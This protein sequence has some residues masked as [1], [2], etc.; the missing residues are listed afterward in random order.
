MGR[1]LERPQV[2][3]VRG[4]PPPLRGGPLTLLRFLRR[5]GML[6][7]RY[8]RLFLRWAWLKLRWRRRLQTDRRSFLVARRTFQLGRVAGRGLRPVAG[9][10]PGPEISPPRRLPESGGS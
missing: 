7:H 6:D 2:V 8:A 9:V 4:G 1:V 10:R 3:E 5:N